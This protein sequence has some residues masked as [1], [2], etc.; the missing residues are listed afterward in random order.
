MKLPRC[1]EVHFSVPGAAAVLCAVGFASPASAQARILEVVG[2]PLQNHSRAVATV[3][4]LDGDG[5]DEVVIG[6]SKA[7]SGGQRRG[8]VEVRSG[9][10]G[11]EIFTFVGG[12]DFDELGFAV[13]NAGDMNDDGFDDIAAGT[14]GGNYARV[15]SGADGSIL[16]TF[17]TGNTGDFFGY[18]VDGAGDVNGDGH[19]D[20]IVGT[21]RILVLAAGFARVFSGLTGTALYTFPGDTAFD[22]FGNA[23]AGGGDAN[24]DG[25]PDLVVGGPAFDSNGTDAGRVRVFS[26]SNGALLHLFDGEEANDK[27]GAS[28]DFV[29][30]VNGDGKDEIVVGAPGCSSPLAC[31]GKKGFV[32]LF[33][34]ATGEVRSTRRGRQANALFGGSVAGLGDIDGDGRGDFAIGTSGADGRMIVD[35]GRVDVLSGW[36]GARLFE[37]TGELALAG[38]GASVAGRGDLNGDGVPDVFSGAI[39]GRARAFSIALGRAGVAISLSFGGA[40]ELSVVAGP[41]HAHSLF[42]LMGTFLGTEPGI[43]VSGVHLPLNMGLF[44]SFS[45]A[46]IL[47]IVFKSGNPHQV[48]KLLS[49]SPLLGHVGH[50]DAFGEFSAEL[51]IPASEFTSLAGLTA[52]HAYLVFD[53]GSKKAVFASNAVPL[54]LLP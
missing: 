12:A 39:G 42:A 50:L 54:Q 36:D 49:P 24:G 7:P 17:T 38:L 15:W 14:F 3:R 4:D 29:D 32:R 21:N 19:D 18:S 53:G 26:G 52:H 45:G 8:R 33:D 46:D 6:S 27:F 34:G 11:Q 16:R 20:L 13:A 9:R 51:A 41:E 22:G 48:K 40:Q 10:T 37:C 35:N 2:D 47:W 5:F 31:P 30:D 1:K 43:P 28:V 25:V 23:V 44:G